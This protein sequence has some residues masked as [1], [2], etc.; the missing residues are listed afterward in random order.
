M[1]QSVQIIRGIRYAG[2]EVTKSEVVTDDTASV[3][4][5]N[6]AAST[7]GEAHQLPLDVSQLQAVGII[8]DQAGEI[9]INNN[10][11]G[12]A[13]TLTPDMPHIWSIGSGLTNPLG[14]VDI[15]TIY[16]D[17]ESTTATMRLRIITLAKS[18]P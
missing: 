11:N 14:S 12:T 7:V 16:V 10:S 18:E 5:V 2:E 3:L 4:D 13:I 17:N 9:R 6:V 1:S 15:T 8:A